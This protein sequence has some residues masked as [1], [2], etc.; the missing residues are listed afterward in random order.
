M[1]VDIDMGVE[2]VQ[3]IEKGNLKGDTDAGTSRTLL[4]F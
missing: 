1:E 3:G 4:F 2:I